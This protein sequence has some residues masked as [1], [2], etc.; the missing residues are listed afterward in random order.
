M[1]RFGISHRFHKE[2]IKFRTTTP[3]KILN[4][5]ERETAQAHLSHIA[6]N[7]AKAFEASIEACAKLGIGCFR[8]PVLFPLATH[9][10]L[11]YTLDSL[12]DYKEIQGI[13]YHIGQEALRLG[14]RI[15]FEP[16]QHCTLG[17]PREEITRQSIKELNLILEIQKLL[18]IDDAIILSLGKPYGNDGETLIRISERIN[19]FDEEL[20][21]RLVLM[22]DDTFTAWETWTFT[23]VLHLD[24]AFDWQADRLNPEEVAVKPEIYFTTYRRYEPIYRL[25]SFP[26]GKT[27][28][29]D[30][31]IDENDIDQKLL[32]WAYENNVTFELEANYKEYAI[33][34]VLDKL[35][36]AEHMGKK[37]QSS[38]SETKK[39]SYIYQP[40][41]KV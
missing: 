13:C 20:R 28:G 17:C 34:K 11:G 1:L 32:S 8:P 14:I 35:I 26:P 27:S 22:N 9:E 24:C 29:Q 25:G 18:R 39:E 3:N 15:I 5:G 31:Y 40:L 6:L 38:F 16:T 12:S 10:T 41:Q 4:G 21:H 23:R 33:K 37:M 36:I 2:K 30:N 19:T 7:N